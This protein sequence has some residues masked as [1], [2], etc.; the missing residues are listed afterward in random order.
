MEIL[1][2]F[3]AIKV[4][5]T[6]AETLIWAGELPQAIKRLMGEVESLDE[7]ITRLL[8]AD[9]NAGLQNLEQAGRADSLQRESLLQE[10]RARFNLAVG[11]QSGFRQGVALLGLAVCHHLLGDRANCQNAL[12][13]LVNL[14]PAIS[15]WS[16][17][18]AVL[19][20]RGPEPDQTKTSYYDER[21][22][23]AIQRSP[24]ARSLLAIQNAA[25][26][27]LVDYHA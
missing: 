10:A 24:E 13:R 14:P 6:A 7:K 8:D 20:T 3:S 18:A 16:V 22:N 26:A 5:K 11:E 17:V 12:F 4:T 21:I 15:D 9:L 2:I 23:S 1:S 19:R 27:V 25:K